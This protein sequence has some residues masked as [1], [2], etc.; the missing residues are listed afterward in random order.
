VGPQD[1]QP[2]GNT[3]AELSLDAPCGVCLRGSVHPRFTLFNHLPPSSFCSHVIGASP[4]RP[5]TS[6]LQSHACFIHG[7]AECIA[8]S[9]CM[10][11][12]LPQLT[13]GCLH[14]LYRPKVAS[15]AWWSTCCL[16]TGYMSTLYAHFTSTD[17]YILGYAYLIIITA[18]CDSPISLHTQT[19]CQSLT[20]VL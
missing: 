10:K 3:I 14:D 15:L 9:A 8:I 18:C 12:F 5:L 13:R 19:Q 20:K 1:N 17:Q 2:S 11:D 6:G 16:T 4:Y 7:T